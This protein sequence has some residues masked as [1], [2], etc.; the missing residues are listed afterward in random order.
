MAKKDSVAKNSNFRSIITDIRKGEFAPVYLLMGEESYY[1]DKIVEYLEACVVKD[2]DDREFNFSTF[3]G[4]DADIGQVIATCQEFPFMSDKRIVFLKEAQSR[5]NAKVVLEQLAPYVSHPNNQ[6]VFVLT[7][8]GDNLNARSALMSAASKSENAIVFKSPKLREYE[9]AAPISD[10]LREKKI[11]IS[12]DAS[13]MLIDFLGTDLTAIF[14]TIDRLIVAGASVTGQITPEM[15]LENVRMTKEFST[16]ELQSAIARK[17]YGK[18]VTIVQSFKRNPKAN[19]VVVIIGFL[20]S[21]FSKLLTAQMSG[22]KTQ[23]GLMEAVGAK[24]T[25]ALRDYEAAMRVYNISQ[26]VNAIHLLR[27][28]DIKSKGVD[29]FQDEHSLLMEFIF[30]VFS[31]NGPKS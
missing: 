24:S 23:A 3:Y 2:E 30:N 29:S 22:Q 26:T 31:G 5:Q 1:I 9:M 28:L 6:C 14:G 17:D 15:I 18:C 20:F 8:K 21:F 10:Y 19:P 16:F 7:F 27:E 12:N 11:A 13:Q 25:Y 4:Q